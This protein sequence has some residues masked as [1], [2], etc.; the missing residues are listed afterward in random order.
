MILGYSFAW[1]PM[2]FIAI[3]NGFFRE[4]VLAKTLS[5][6]RAHQLS[7]LTGILLF[8][9][10]TWLISLSNPPGKPWPWALSGLSLLSCSSS[11]S[12]IGWHWDGTGKREQLSEAK[13]GWIKTA[14]SV[15]TAQPAHIVSWDARLSMPGV[16]F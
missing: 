10:Y 9:G 2:V 15:R 6:L 8:F 14:N 13:L 5:E 11:A 12:G 4:A 7:C 1:I 3:L 16:Q